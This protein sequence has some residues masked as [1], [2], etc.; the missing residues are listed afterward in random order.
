MLKKQWTVLV[1]MGLD[2]ED[3]APMATAAF[4][5]L[6]EMRAVG[7]SDHINVAVQMDTRLFPPVRFLV[8][9]SG[10]LDTTQ[11]RGLGLRRESNAGH[12]GTLSS[13]LEYALDKL[14]ARR[15]LLILWGHGL[16]VGFSVEDVSPALADVVYDGGDALTV[17]ELGGALRR[18]TRVNGRPL[19]L[20]GFDACYMSATEV[21]YEY[22]G[23]VDFMI[24]SQMTIPFQGW[25]YGKILAFL[26]RH[27]RRTP[28]SLAKGIVRAVV[29][30][31]AG[32]KSATV[33]QTAL[34]PAAADEVGSA[35]AR[36]VEALNRTIDRAQRDAPERR[37]ILRVFAQA[38]YVQARQ[39]LDFAD[40]CRLLAD[41]ARDPTVSKAARAAVKVLTRRSR[42]LVLEHRRKGPETQRLN[43]AS[44]Y[45][46]WLKA[47]GRDQN[48]NLKP[49]EY[50]KLEF[51]QTTGW[52]RV[53]DRL[54]RLRNH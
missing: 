48:V 10:S 12:P 25:P 37:R 20:L 34:C 33:T 41:T 45:V 32:D 17:P 5:D 7:S 18:F 43:G 49:K 2:D 11:S 54:G 3:D 38:K 21:S 47:R 52:L 51:A 29:D 53:N 30:S 16:G 22:R 35:T 9:P 19:D 24:A 4:A 39:F 13:F 15:Y 1:Y 44:I 23:L 27:P 46:R 36:L 28:E 6:E 14:P 26:R 50:G 8:M 40:L 31:Y 42:G